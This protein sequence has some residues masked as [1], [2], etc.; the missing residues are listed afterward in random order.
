[1]MSILLEYCSAAAGLVDAMAEGDRHKVA[2]EKV[3]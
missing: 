1:M 2:Y 3:S